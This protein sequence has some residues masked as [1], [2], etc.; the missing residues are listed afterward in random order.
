MAMYV[1]KQLYQQLQNHM[2][3]PGSGA[4]FPRNRF[5]RYHDICNQATIIPTSLFACVKF[6]CIIISHT[7]TLSFLFPLP[8]S[9]NRSFTYICDICGH[10]L[11]NRED[12]RA[13]H[14]KRCRIAAATR[15]IIQSRERYGHSVF[16]EA[17]LSMFR[18]VRALSMGEEKSQSDNRI[19][20]TVLS[21][22]LRVRLKAIHG[23]KI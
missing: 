20:Q 23:L 12:P 8:M 4:D 1:S 18:E 5:P 7:L 17:F 16:D 3:A 14:Q 21:I 11:N 22:R 10:H 15:S 2:L 6:K 13:A 9:Q 19:S